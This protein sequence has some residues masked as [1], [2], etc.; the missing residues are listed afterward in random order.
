MRGDGEA[1]GGDD[2]APTA[3]IHERFNAAVFGRF[4]T[5]HHPIFDKFESEHVS[6]FLPNAH[7]RNQAE[8][9]IK[10]SNRWFYLAYVLLAL[11]A[12]AALTLFLLPTKRTYTSRYCKGSEYSVRDWRAATVSRASRTEISGSRDPATSQRVYVSVRS[13]SL[14]VVLPPL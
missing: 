4:G 1:V 13:R 6:Q 2:D 5:A 14:A 8:L 10:G 7:A 11:V 3:L 9:G 12:F